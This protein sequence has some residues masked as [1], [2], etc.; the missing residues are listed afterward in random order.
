M[1]L[2][3]P[4]IHALAAFEAA[5]RLGGF[6]QAAEELCVTPS[7]ISHRIRQLEEHL[8]VQLFERSAQGVRLTTAGRLYLESVREAFDKLSGLAGKPGAKT[9][10]R[11]R[12][13]TP[14]TFARQLLVPRLAEFYRLYPDI[15]LELHL[16]IPL[17]E[18][19]AET[20]DVEVRYGTGDYDDVG[21]V[22]LFDET[23]QPACS[24]DYLKSA[25]PFK[26]PRD[27]KGAVLLR[28]PLEAWRPWFAAAELDWP[29]PGHGPVFNDL[30]LLMEAAASGQG[31][32][33]T[34]S[35]LAADWMDSKRLVPLFDVKTVS[36]RTYYVAC[37]RANA[38]RPEVAAFVEWLSGAL[39]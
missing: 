18:A 23:L 6:A 14:P 11:V 39:R 37:R 29:E 25:G 8:G 35:R 22:K 2:R 1:A 36:P 16:V 3:I 13:S 34:R 15:E 9:V 30:G 10:A 5:S 33:L 20:S 17:L 38:Q 28:T 32:A 12:V 26:A 27:L 31:V 19:K 21:A 24:P 7:A 4:P